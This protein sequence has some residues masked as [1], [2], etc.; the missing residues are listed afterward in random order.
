MAKKNIQGI[1]KENFRELLNNIGFKLEDGIGEI[2][3]KTYP[4]HSGYAIKI[5]FEEETINYRGTSGN[6]ITVVRDTT[7]NFS[8]GENAV[9]LECVDRLLTLGYKP[10]AIT[11][12][13]SFPNGHDATYL[14]I[15]V[16]EDNKSWWSYYPWCQRE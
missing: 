15:F 4:E 13:K 3:T 6:G 11:L 16:M 5:D 10:K 2:Y 8:D 14:D 7:S 9:V 12:E 1:D